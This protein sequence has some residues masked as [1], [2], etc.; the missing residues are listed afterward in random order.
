MNKKKAEKVMVR[1]GFN[2]VILTKL[3][4]EKFNGHVDIISEIECDDCD[5]IIASTEAYVVGYEDEE[6][7][8]CDE[9]GNYLDS[10]QIRIDFGND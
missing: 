6:G 5:P 1:L 3:E 7:R 10:D 4:N 2:D 9:L 8:E